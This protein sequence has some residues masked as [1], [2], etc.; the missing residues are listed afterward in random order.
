MGKN[1]I[2]AQIPIWLDKSQHN[3]KKLGFVGDDLGFVRTQKTTNPKL[4]PTNPNF[5][6][7][8][9]ICPERFGI[10]PYTKTDKSQIDADNS[11]IFVK[12]WEL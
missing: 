6:E 9:G 12:S 8:V 7:K 5:L 1:F 10:C 3:W 2:Y 11:Q 4:S